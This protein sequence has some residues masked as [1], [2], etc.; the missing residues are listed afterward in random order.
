LNDQLDER[1]EDVSIED[2]MNMPVEVP[3]ETKRKRR[4]Y[5]KYPKPECT[6]AERRLEAVRCSRVLAVAVSGIPR[7]MLRRLRRRSSV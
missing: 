1:L 4:K 7:R 5:R 3:A 2:I 6:T